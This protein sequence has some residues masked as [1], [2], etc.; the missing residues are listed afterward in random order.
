M[1]RRP[2]ADETI[3]QSTKPF[4]AWRAELRKR[5]VVINPPTKT[6]GSAG[7][8]PGDSIMRTVSFILAFAFV[9]AGS[10]MAGWAEGG[11]PGVGT[12]AYTGTPI[13]APASLVVASR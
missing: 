13:A 11:L 2:R 12:F 9:V 8:L 6:A 5:L 7:Y 1:F 10:S 3:P 4:F